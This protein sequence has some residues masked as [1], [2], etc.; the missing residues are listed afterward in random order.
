MD[1]DND[2]TDDPAE[3][4]TESKMDERFPDINYCLVP[5]HH[6][7]LEKGTHSSAPRYH[8]TFPVEAITVAAQYVKVKVLLYKSYPFFAG[9]A[10]EAVRFLFGMK[11]G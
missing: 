1:I 4:I 7:M 8:V 6:Y 5:S 10:L 2:H 9:N 3:F 11:V